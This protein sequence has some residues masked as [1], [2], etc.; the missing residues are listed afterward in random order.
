[1]Q[2]F[3]TLRQPLGVVVVGG[4]VVSQLLALLITPARYLSID[5]LATLARHILT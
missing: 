1:M 3:R 2:I 4:L 5:R